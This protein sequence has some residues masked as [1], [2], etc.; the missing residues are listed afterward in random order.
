MRKVLAGIVTVVFALSA[1][2]AVGLAAR[3]IPKPQKI[4]AFLDTVL[5]PQTGQ[6]QFCAEYK[7]Q[8][9]IELK[10]IQPVHNQY[11]EKLRLSFAS[12]DIPDVVEIAESNYVQYSGDG[13]FVDLSKYVKAS[14]P[15]RKAVKLFDQYRIKGKLYGIPVGVTNG[16]VTY[17]R[18]DWLSKLH[19]KAPTTWT[20]YYNML[21]AFTYNDPD[22]NGKNDT[23]GVTA[24]STGEGGV[25]LA[26]N[27]YR[28]FY[29]NA[30]PDFIKRN[31]KWVDGFMQKEFKSAL[32]RLRQAYKEK[33][34]DPEIFTNKSSTCREKFE[35]GKAG[36]FTY[37]AGLWQTR[38]EDDLQKNLGKTA[39]IISIP[40]LK[41]S[42]YLG[43]VQAVNAITVK[44]KNPQ[45][46]FK[47]FLEYCNDGNKGQ[48]LFC[49]GVEN[50]HWKKANGSIIALPAL[51]NP[52]E[53][54]Q[55]TFRAPAEVI[56]P[57]A[58]GK[59]PIPLDKR[60]SQSL[61]N[62]KVNYKPARLQVYTDS[63]RKIEDALNKARNDVFV[64]TLIEN[65][66]VDQALAEYKKNY[67]KLK[68][69]QVLKEMNAKDHN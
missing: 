51:D 41:G 37:W 56:V 67:A 9:G 31:G 15:L 58:G 44:A 30:S 65:R 11:Y 38:L 57:W 48:M 22:Q 12:G 6:A 49:H 42:Y 28:E 36:V 35:S 16:P 20:E 40:A 60:I 46:I 66:T 61:R 25:S 45:G 2:S 23:Y 19:L 18:Q 69:D 59:D 14:I 5:T 64:R 10:I 54:V 21:K 3:Q 52:K 8:T 17:I 55:K 33:L 7:K 68:V 29:Q 53:T 27:S 39:T 1:C 4:V 47:Y 24:G 63:R 34:I 13:A 26:D 43:K 32:G 50:V 62:F